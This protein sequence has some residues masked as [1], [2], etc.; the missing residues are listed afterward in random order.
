MKKIIYSSDLH[1]FIKTQ[2]FFLKENMKFKC[3]QTI[4]FNLWGDFWPKPVT[5]HYHDHTHTNTCNSLRCLL[6]E[7]LFLLKKV[8]FMLIHIH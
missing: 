3:N 4:I 6:P 1:I 5:S 2:N 7:L 8:K